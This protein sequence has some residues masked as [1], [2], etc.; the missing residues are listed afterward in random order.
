MKYH[1]HSRASTRSSLSFLSLIS[2]FSTGKCGIPIVNTT[3]GLLQ[4]FSPYPNVNAYLGIPY[5]QPPIG[6]LRFAPPQPYTPKDTSVRD[7]YDS[8]PGCFQLTYLTAFSD[9]STGFKESENMMSI[10]IVRRIFISK[11]M[12][13]SDW[14]EIAVETSNGLKSVVTGVDLPLW[15]WVHIRSEW[16]AQLQRDQLRGRAKRH[17]LCQYQVSTHSFFLL[18]IYLLIISDSYRVNIF[19][20]PNSPAIKTKNPGLLDQRLAIEWL[21]DNIASFGGDPNR[22]ILSGHSAGSI[23]TAYWSYIYEK[24]PIVSGF[25]ELSGQPGLLATDDGSSWI[26]IANSTGCSNTDTDAELACMRNVPARTLKRAMSV[27]NVP[28]LTDPVING[29]NPVIDNVTVFSVA[30]YA[31]RGKA[32]NFAKLVYSPILSSHGF[33]ER[34]R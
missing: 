31:A 28:S 33:W 1:T 15:R 16:H 26:S 7:C 23:S 13:R 17:H 10:N 32:G 24:D 11:G 6:D 8:T 20:F 18:R 3:S 22:M 9:R 4:G 2:L 14:H 34:R 29:G 21:R 30:E 12:W 5:A 27:N 19:G 25:I